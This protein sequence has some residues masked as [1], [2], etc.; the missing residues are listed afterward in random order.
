MLAPVWV[1]F[2]WGEATSRDTL[3]GGA[4]LLAAI[5]LNTIGAAARPSLAAPEE[6]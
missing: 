6:P 3:I 1:W 4:V 2:F 5:A